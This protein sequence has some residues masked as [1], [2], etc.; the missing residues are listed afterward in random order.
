MFI[1][2]RVACLVACVVAVIIASAAAAAAAAFSESDAAVDAAEAHAARD[3][4]GGVAGVLSR[5][6]LAHLGA[7]PVAHHA[8]PDAVGG[9]PHHHHHHHHEAFVR[10]RDELHGRLS[11]AAGTG[12]GTTGGVADSPPYPPGCMGDTGAGQLLSGNLPLMWRGGI[13]DMGKYAKCDATPDMQFC[14]LEMKLMCVSDALASRVYPHTLYCNGPSNSNAVGLCYNRTQCPTRRNLTDALL[15][16]SWS[17]RDAAATAVYPVCFGLEAAYRY[18]V[19]HTIPDCNPLLSYVFVDAWCDAKTPLGAAYSDPPRVVAVKACVIGLLLLAAVATAV[20]LVRR[21]ARGLRADFGDDGT[22]DGNWSMSPCGERERSA[23]DGRSF[24]D[25]LLIGEAPESTVTDRTSERAATRTSYSQI[26]RGED[27]YVVQLAAGAGGGTSGGGGGGGGRDGGD[28]C[29]GGCCGESCADACTCHAVTASALGFLDAFDVVSGIKDFLRPMQRQLPTDFFDG[30]RTAAMVLVVGGH[31]LYFPFDGFGQ[32]TQNSQDVLDFISSYQAI[33]ILPAFLAVD[34][35]FYLSGF[36]GMFLMAAQLDKIKSPSTLARMPL[37]VLAY[38][39]R[40]LRLTP[41]L[42]MI[43]AVR[44]YVLPGTVSGPLSRTFTQD[45]TYEGCKTDLWASALY[46]MNTDMTKYSCAPVSWYLDCDMQCFIFVPVWAL[47]CWA[48]RGKV[49]QWLMPGLLLAGTAALYGVA[50]WQHP[51]TKRFKEADGKRVVGYIRTVDR[52]TPYAIGVLVAMLCEKGGALVAYLRESKRACYALNIVA[53][54]LAVTIWNVTWRLV[55]TLFRDNQVGPVLDYSGHAL[56]MLWGVPLGLVTMT[57]LAGFTTV[58]TRFFGHPFFGVVAKLTY[59]LYLCHP[60]VIGYFVAEYHRFHDF[61]RFNYYVT[62]GGVLLVAAA[63]A[64]VLFL[65][66]DR[67]VGVF[68]G[69]LSGLL[70]V[71]K[72]AKKSR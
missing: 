4:L 53:L 34:T 21:A 41:T 38:I 35:F 71:K 30:M 26:D 10:V 43:I 72:G 12:T 28:G 8:R 11:G 51:I 63:A 44:V 67:P 68:C 42:L 18:P 1:P 69:W 46:V 45:P 36:L 40:Y 20:G 24:M 66:V 70:G 14:V 6:T 39:N 61:E 3:L 33:T 25:R 13:A 2:R 32:Y 54:V 48:L 57:S 56:Y 7:P 64:F 15:A 55:R 62:F 58:F 5:D 17:N 60:I 16:W 49:P 29:C 31:V 50:I 47:L 59:G 22:A 65:L 19:T 23:G 9:S 52:A 37:V 27:L